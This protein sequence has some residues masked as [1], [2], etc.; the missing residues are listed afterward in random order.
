MAITF[1]S[2][3]Q[4]PMDHQ[5]GVR[6]SG[7]YVGGQPVYLTPSNWPGTLLALSVFAECQINI[8]FQMLKETIC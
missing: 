4:T 7:L 6:G 3:F 8:A 1:E 5:R 2:R